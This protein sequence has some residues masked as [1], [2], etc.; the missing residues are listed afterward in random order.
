VSN[1][2]VRQEN[3]R[4]Q[5]VTPMRAEVSNPGRNRGKRKAS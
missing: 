1:R 4:Q 2:S 5:K 3:Q